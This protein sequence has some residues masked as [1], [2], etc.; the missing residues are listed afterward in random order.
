MIELIIKISLSI[1]NFRN[2][3]ICH[4][5]IFKNDRQFVGYIMVLT[6][7]FRDILSGVTRYNSRLFAGYK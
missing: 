5:I 2:T 7:K 4:S 1:S 6:E 3:I